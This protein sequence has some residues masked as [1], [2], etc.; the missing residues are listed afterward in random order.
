MFSAS[1]YGANSTNFM[2]EA[3][4]SP[5][6]VRS[7]AVPFPPLSTSPCC[8]EQAGEGNLFPGF[9][10]LAEAGQADSGPSR[11]Y[12]LNRWLPA[13]AVARRLA[14]WAGLRKA[15]LGLPVVALWG[16]GGAHLKH[17]AVLKAYDVPP[18]VRSS[19]IKAVKAEQDSS[20]DAEAVAE[21]A[22]DVTR[23]AVKESTDAIHRVHQEVEEETAG[24][25]DL[26]DECRN[27]RYKFR[28]EVNQAA[29][30][31]HRGLFQA[32]REIRGAAEAFSRDTTIKSATLAI[33]KLESSRTAYGSVRSRLIEE[34]ERSHEEEVRAYT[35]EAYHLEPALWE[36]SKK[37]WESYRSCLYDLMA[38]VAHM[39]RSCLGEVIASYALYIRLARTYETAIET[40]PHGDRSQ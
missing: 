6:P 28:R 11:Q 16:C 17:P 24:L 7:W 33:T 23:Q 40:L 35:E 12:R 9:L 32:G 39:N 25:A 5:A 8:R 29:V 26:L 13:I 4:N 3:D 34:V 20:L 18:E 15:L 21:L 36:D 27:S 22:L 2:G 14:R 38:G 37:S 30:G 10:A 19:I 1:R 31:I